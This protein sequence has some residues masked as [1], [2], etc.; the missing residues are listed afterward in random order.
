MGGTNSRPASVSNRPLGSQQGNQQANQQG[1]DPN[2]VMRRAVKDGQGEELIITEM[3]DKF[4]QVSELFQGYNTSSPAEIQERLRT[5]RTTLGSQDITLSPEI[6][7]AME[8][9]HNALISSIDKKITTSNLS[10]QQR[11]SARKEALKNMQ[12]E[13][14]LS[15]LTSNFSGDIDTQK[16]R[17]LENLGIATNAEIGQSV[18]SIFDTVKSLK[19]KYK[20]F[21]Y[22]YIELNVFMLLY[23]Q[24]SYET[25]QN[26]VDN[27]LQFNKIKNQSRDELIAEAF[28]SVSALMNDAQ[29]QATPTDTD[30]LKKIMTALQTNMQEKDEIMNNKLNQVIQLGN[31]NIK[32][33]VD[34][35]S[36]ATKTKFRENLKGGSEK[37]QAF[38]DLKAS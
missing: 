27:V 6:T 1:V 20:F 33:F 17:V 18:S 5:I 24:Y 21:E 4:K 14:I 29:L 10:P 23:V 28:K 31:E 11:N 9:V 16:N 30:S 3:K 32:G 26:F 22:K 34:G 7:T 35:L 37:P 36:E 38:F 12:F 8:S 13:E 25:L 2:D 19:V 15:V